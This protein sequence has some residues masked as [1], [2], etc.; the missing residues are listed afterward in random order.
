MVKIG[1]LNFSTDIFERL[2]DIAAENQITETQIKT[3]ILEITHYTN[4]LF[5]IPNDS[6]QYE[7]N[8]IDYEVFEELYKSIHKDTTAKIIPM[9]RVAGAI[10]LKDPDV[11]GYVAFSLP[12]EF[13]EN[14]NKGFTLTEFLINAAHE[15]FER[16]LL[17]ETLISKIYE[18]ARDDYHGKYT[19]NKEKNVSAFILYTLN[20]DLIPLHETITY[21]INYLVEDFIEANYIIFNQVQLPLLELEYNNQ[22]KIVTEMFIKTQF[23]GA[24][25]NK[26]GKEV[27]YKRF[28]AGM[29]ILRIA[30]E[31][32]QEVCN[33]FLTLYPKV[34]ANLKAETSDL[35]RFIGATIQQVLE[36]HGL[37]NLLALY[38]QE[39]AKL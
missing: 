20:K 24:H 5:K 6:D 7:V 32:F 33:D 12:K 35:T 18:Y 8:V 4:E 25:I 9:F 23:K 16:F 15:R 36:K 26:V 30:T 34:K 38:D 27:A 14:I 1:F 37:S 28:N 31:K 22:E 29:Y 39:Y 17:K 3:S 2:I 19:L 11:P 21:A 13:I 10:N